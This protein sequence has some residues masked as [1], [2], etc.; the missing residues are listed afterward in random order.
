MIWCLK[1][2]FVPSPSGRQRYNVLGCINAVSHNLITVTNCTYINSD[3]I[4]DMLDKISNCNYKN[5]ITIVLD[6]ARYQRCKKV[7]EYAKKLNIELL[8][9]PSY[10]PN[11]NII[12]RL[13]KFVKKKLQ[14]NYYAKFENFRIAVESI[15]NEVDDKY[16]NDIKSLLNLRFQTFDKVSLLSA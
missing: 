11:L 2:I 16:K 4:C 9:L 6:N 7:T 1:R 13:W 8:F 12:E 5:P 10:S 14:N 3:S 15:L